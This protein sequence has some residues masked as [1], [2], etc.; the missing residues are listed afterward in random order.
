MDTNVPYIWDDICSTLFRT[1]NAITRPKASASALS[2]KHKPLEFLSFPPELHIKIISHL[3]TTASVCLGITCHYLYALHRG[4]HGNVYFNFFDTPQL[5]YLLGD[6][7]GPEY[8]FYRK[9]FVFLRRGKVEEMRQKELE[10]WEG[11][12]HRMMI[13]PMTKR[14]GLIERLMEGW[15]SG[16]GVNA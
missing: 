4:L 11:Y 12:F 15:E 14:V 5:P 8:V 10:F 9:N 7:I 16:F 6:W 3:D 1:L 2:K 13:F